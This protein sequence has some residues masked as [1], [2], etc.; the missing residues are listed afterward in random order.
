M[1]RG[2]PP[3]SAPPSW[4]GRGGRAIHNEI[5]RDW[6]FQ[7]H[8]ERYPCVDYFPPSWRLCSQCNMDL[9]AVQ[10]LLG[11]TK[12]HQQSRTEKRPAPVLKW[13]IGAF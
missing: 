1:L 9:R 7:F 11:H 13:R 10:L 2:A 3:R 5:G 6:Q 12:T 8:I 4:A